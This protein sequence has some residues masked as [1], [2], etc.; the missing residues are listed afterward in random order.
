MSLS[1]QNTEITLHNQFIFPP[2][3]KTF[4]VDHVTDGL[5]IITALKLNT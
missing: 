4:L 2:W 5:R 1:Q 3:Y